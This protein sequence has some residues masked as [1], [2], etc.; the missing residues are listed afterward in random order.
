MPHK[1]KS[2]EQV[3]GEA[4]AEDVTAYTLLYSCSGNSSFES[5]L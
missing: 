2:V 5:L 1:N 4:V 3:G